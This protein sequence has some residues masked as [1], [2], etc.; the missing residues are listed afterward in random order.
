MKE[1]QYSNWTAWNCHFSRSVFQFW[2]L[3]S[4]DASKNFHLG[5]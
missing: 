3:T 4:S 1:M 2:Q 5:V